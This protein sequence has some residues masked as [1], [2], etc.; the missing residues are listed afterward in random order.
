MSQDTKVSRKYQLSGKGK[1]D[2]SH[3]SKKYQLSSKG[4]GSNDQEKEKR[5]DHQ[6][7]K[8]SSE[9]PMVSTFI[10]ESN[11]FIN[12]ESPQYSLLPGPKPYIF[13][14]MRV[15]GIRYPGY[16]YCTSR[17]I[18]C[19]SMMGEACIACQN[20][21]SNVVKKEVQDLYSDDE[22]DSE[23]QYSDFSNEV[24]T[25]DKQSSCWVNKLLDKRTFLHVNILQCWNNQG[26]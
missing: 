18:R 25:L 3:V 8:E 9:G 1:G 23:S 4:I 19:Q 10:Y 7:R 16:E 2:V 15:V 11:H 26:G 24:I 13:A 12:M 22:S 17:N 5:G 6:K 20:R 14:I 21:Y